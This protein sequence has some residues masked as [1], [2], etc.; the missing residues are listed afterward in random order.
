M[1]LLVSLSLSIIRSE[2]PAVR[3]REY[4]PGR[5]G[6]P[7]QLSRELLVLRPLELIPIL[8]SG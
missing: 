7:A 6:C 1:I 2:Q 5:H 8:S 3:R 4:E